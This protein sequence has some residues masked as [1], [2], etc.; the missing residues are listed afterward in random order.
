[1]VAALSDWTG[2]TGYLDVCRV[3]GVAVQQLGL[4]VYQYQMNDSFCPQISSN[5]IF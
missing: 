1:M 4:L 3:G 2:S 5:Q